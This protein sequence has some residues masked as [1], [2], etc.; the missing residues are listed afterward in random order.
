M[1]SRGMPGLNLERRPEGSLLLGDLPRG[2]VR[3]LEEE[4]ILQL[5]M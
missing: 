3:E 5:G 2:Q 1:A 4:E